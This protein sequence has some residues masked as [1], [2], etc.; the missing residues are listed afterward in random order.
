[1]G[2]KNN[3]NLSSFLVLFNILPHVLTV[4][5]WV[6]VLFLTFF[7]WKFLA[8]STS[9]PA[10]GKWLQALFGV[11]AFALVFSQYGTIVGDEAATSL[12]IILV[13]VKFFEVRGP[14]DVVVL[15]FLCYFLLLTRLIASQSIATTIFLVV[16]GILITS[17]MAFHNAPQDQGRTWALAKRAFSLSLQAFPLVIALFF[18]FP[19][20]S[21][22][23][24]QRSGDTQALTGFSDTVKP[25]SIGKLIPSDELAFRVAFNNTQPPENLLYWR[26]AE[27]DHSE[28]L[29][30]SKTKTLLPSLAQVRVNQSKEGPQE[31]SYEI[32]LEP[33]TTP[34]IFTLDWP[35]S[36]N[37]SRKD[38]QPPVPQAGRT[39]SNPTPIFQ[40]LTYQATSNLSPFSIDWN[41]EFDLKR[42]LQAPEPGPSGVNA[43]KAFALAEQVKKNSQTSRDVVQ[44]FLQYFKS[45]NFAYDLSPPPSELESFLFT[46]KVGYCEHYAASLAT[47]L[48]WAGVP[49]RVIV[50]FQGGTPGLIKN[51]LIVRMLDAHAWVEYWSK[52]ERTWRRVDPTAVIAPS[53]ISLGAQ[54]FNTEFLQAQGRLESQFPTLGQ[55]VAPGFLRAYFQMR[56]HL[57]TAEATWIGFLLKYDFTFQ[58][59]F[60][61]SLGL[62][63]LWL[64]LVVFVVLLALMLGVIYLFYLKV[65]DR[66][67][68]DLELYR[69]LCAKLARW[70]LARGANEGPLAYRRRLEQHLVAH[71]RANVFPIMDRIID[72]RYGQSP[73]AVSEYRL[74]R[75]ALKALKK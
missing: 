9:V 2:F 75:R 27:L 4:P 24:W 69:L 66:I 52:E 50:G 44:N 73:I 10:P 42:Y 41:S 19:R 26:G 25:G 22:G 15:T 43:P 37:L 28:G 23:L 14:R 70:G 39:F 48:R 33:M 8:D 32:T 56:L 57:A 13:G 34:W 16:D 17:L 65:S 62:G 3:L 54:R 59:S 61:N 21:T 45:R 36:L 7:A 68:P 31:V 29:I 30:W 11:M 71:L 53:R 51:Y 49:A 58:Q 74:Y 47:L 67:Q 72:S 46:T 12:L 60:L 5:Y 18:L 63:S 55:F 38:W 40:R 6:T 20:F 64:R 35:L 1:M